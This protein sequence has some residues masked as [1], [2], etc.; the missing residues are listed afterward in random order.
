MEKEIPK[1]VNDN[2]QKNNSGNN[3]PNIYKYIMEFLENNKAYTISYAF[4][5]TAS[6]INDVI[7]P[8][9]YGKIIDDIGNKLYATGERCSD[10]KTGDCKQLLKDVVIVG[11]LYAGCQIMFSIMDRMDAYFIPNIQAFLREKI[12]DHIIKHHIHHA[13]DIETGGIIGK[14]SKLPVVI[15]DLILQIRNYIL[16]GI[17]VLVSATGYFFILNPV[18]G[19]LSMLGLLLFFFLMHFAIKITLNSSEKLNN[20]YGKLNA[21]L[22][23]LI[24]NLTNIYSSMMSKEELERILKIQKET[25]EGYSSNIKESSNLKILFNLTYVLIFSFINGYA[26]YLF[27][28]SKLSLSQLTSVFII[29]LYVITQMG[30][31]SGEISSWIYNIGFINNMQKYIDKLSN[32]SSPL[33]KDNTKRPNNERSESFRENESYKNKE[34][35]TNDEIFDNKIDSNNFICFKNIFFSIGERQIFSNLNLNIPKG[36]KTC[37]LG[38]IGSGKSILLS[39]IMK[40]RQPQNGNIFINGKDINDIPTDQ[41]RNKMAYIKQNSKL[42][43][44]SLL[45]NIIYGTKRDISELEIKKLFKNFEIEDVFYGR[46][47]EDNVGKNACFL[48]GGQKQIVLFLRTYL[49]GGEIIILD[50]PT[51]ALDFE[52]KLK[53]M[54]LMI[55]LFSG[56]TIICVT[57]DYDISS[58]FDNFILMKD[59]VANNIKEL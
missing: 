51:S 47:L 36:I 30:N 10:Y 46:S 13:D 52:T 19:S 56:K 23:D 42:F 29:V 11:S 43:N 48:S 8:Y 39:L 57:H 7:L 58:Y 22:T 53:I 20:A 32:I 2:N 55:K 9:F 45:E 24:D 50:E 28:K 37:I 17:Y 21:E 34:F 31:I 4:L 33:Q 14:I 16:P 35:F 1:N 40:Y 15:S 26:Y 18:L 38:K 44:R 41:L 59:I 12:I 3:H 27:N 5:S 54:K 49:K 25:T 6:I